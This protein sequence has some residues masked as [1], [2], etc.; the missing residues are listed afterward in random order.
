MRRRTLL[1]GLIVLGAGLTLGTPAKA[2]SKNTIG[3]PT[4][5]GIRG[6]KKQMIQGFTLLINNDVYKHNK[7]ERWKRKPI[8]VLDL[9]LGTIVAKL[10]EKYVK[11]LQR[12]LIW[13]EWEDTSDPDLERK[14][15]A[16]YYGVYGNV[17]LW[18]MGKNK[19]PK[20][21]NNIE[22]INMKSLTR[23]H[24]PG[25]KLERCVLLHELS[26][27]VQH[28]T[29]SIGMNNPQ[30]KAA[31]RQAMSR[32]LYDEAKDIYGRIRK[33][34]YA[35]KNE[36]EYFA[37]LSCAYLDKLHYYPFNAEDLKKHDPIGY[38]LMERIWGSRK[39][40]DTALKAKLEKEASKLLASAQTMY[41]TGKKK[42]GLDTLDKVM[43]LYPDTKAG[44]SAEKLR[45][46]W[47]EEVEKAQKAA[48]Q[49]DAN[50]DEKNKPK[51]EKKGED[52]KLPA[53]DSA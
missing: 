42:Q 33:P 47:A 44:A 41:V 30:I 6:Y 43:E 12:I 8:D 4:A 5:S 21:A 32:G 50:K 37:E 28:Q 52:D 23:E 46:K 20:K 14:V 36:R 16:K 17:A 40:I 19:H 15:V 1:L 35:S 13:I 3:K 34:T 10:P 11:A 24:Q 18:S 51:E 25:V 31:Y 39:K 49:K 48:S 45:E 53:S 26:H 9:E 38:K 29:P 7:D 2:Q 27:A 22:V